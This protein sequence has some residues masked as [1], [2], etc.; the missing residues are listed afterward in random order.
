MAETQLVTDDP[1]AEEPIYRIDRLEAARRPPERVAPDASVQ[2]AVT[3]MLSKDFSQ[4]PVMT[5]ERCV[6]GIIS[7][8]TI[9]R[10]LMLGGHDAVNGAR[11]QDLMDRHHEIRSDYSLVGA[12]E[13]IVQN[14]YVLI[15]GKDRLITG[16]V[17]VSDLSLQLQQL[18]EPFLRLSEI[19]KHIRRLLTDKFSPEELA[20]SNHSKRGI[21]NV[22][23]LT[24]GGYINL[25]GN[26]ARW[27]K[28]GLNI[29]HEI[30]CELLEHVRN[31]RNDVMH[32]DPAGIQ[33]S[34]LQ[35]LRDFARFLRKL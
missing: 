32:F 19:E 7:W 30:F 22:A 25:L 1:A 2:R 14:Q 26:D 10:K 11:V 4:L 20:A 18:T 27:K 23:D 29:D 13:I 12:I 35:D 9:G 16:I 17:T 34:D 31:I 6:K 5:S 28:L 33:Q 8:S 15:R 24:F 3:I 21:A